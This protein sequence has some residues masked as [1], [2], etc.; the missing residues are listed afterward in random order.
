[1]RTATVTK[2]G[3]PDVFELVRQPDPAPSPGQV[4]IAVAVADTLWLET[5]VRSGAGQDYWPMRPPYVPGNGVAGTVLATGAGVDPALAGRRVVAHTG[6]EGGYADRVA[7][8]AAEVSQIPGQLDF[9]TAAALLHDGPTAL[10]LFDLTKAGP[11]DAVLVVGASGGL[12]LLSVQLA[13]ARCERVVA[14]AR[15]A[16]RARVAELGPDAVIDSGA[17]DWPDQARAALPADGADVVLDNIGGDLGEASYALTAPGGRFSAHGTPSGRFAQ[18]DRDAAR[19]DGRTVT[20]IEAVQMA[21]D[22][23]KRYTEQAL[24]QAAAGTIAPVIGQI[25]PLERA[26]DAHTAIENRTTFGKTLLTTT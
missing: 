18:I 11:G 19:R 10:A 6:S 13:R 4:I 20:G 9:V 17:P 5:M 14:L 15:T 24:A 7:V 22:V 2:F 1:M 25:F 8:A 26:A 23:L 21:P 12:G 16:K 3:G